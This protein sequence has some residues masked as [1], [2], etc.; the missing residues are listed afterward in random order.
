MASV[1]TPISRSELYRGT[2][3][4]KRSAGRPLTEYILK[5]RPSQSRKKKIVEEEPMDLGAKI[6]NCWRCTCP[7]HEAD[8]TDGYAEACA[9]G[10]GRYE[11]LQAKWADA[12]RAVQAAL[13]VSVVAVEEALQFSMH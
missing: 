2:A 11:C 6:S 3:I 12:C 10:S 4:A 5:R 1:A 9:D 13:C 8:V 7:V